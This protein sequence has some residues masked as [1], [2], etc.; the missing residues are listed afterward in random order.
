[1]DNFDWNDNSPEISFLRNNIKFNQAAVNIL[2]SPEK[3]AVG[4]DLSGKNVFAVRPA[5]PGDKMVFAFSGSEKAGRPFYLQGG[6]L[7]KKISREY[8]SIMNAKKIAVN[9]KLTA[10]PEEH[11][12]ICDYTELLTALASN[13]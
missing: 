13:D 3:I 4:F 7:L 12:L 10:V 8:H 1:M 5:C 11:T 6:S 9:I 2:G